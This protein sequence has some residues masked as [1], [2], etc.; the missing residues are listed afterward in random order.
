MQQKPSGEWHIGLENPRLSAM[1]RLV[2]RLSFTF[3]ALICVTYIALNLASLYAADWLGDPIAPGLLTSRG[4]VI[5]TI[6][7]VA[8]VVLTGVFVWIINNRLERLRAEIAEDLA[9]SEQAKGGEAR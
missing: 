1:S 3:T 6:I 2:R 5:A 8:G 9:K 7:M 4:I